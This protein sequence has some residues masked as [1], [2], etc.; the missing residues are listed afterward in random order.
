M[1]ARRHTRQRRR[2]K[3]RSAALVRRAVLKAERRAAQNKR[4]TR[5]RWTSE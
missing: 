5:E 3:I 2:Q 4:P 1:T